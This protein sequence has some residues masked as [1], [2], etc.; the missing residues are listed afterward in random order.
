[1]CTRVDVGASGT[2]S[3]ICISNGERFLPVLVLRPELVLQLS[4][5]SLVRH[6]CLRR[7]LPRELELTS[8]LLW[9][10]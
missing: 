8:N 5:R 3:N 2:I 4:K 1:M 7:G 6:D 9:M 10:L